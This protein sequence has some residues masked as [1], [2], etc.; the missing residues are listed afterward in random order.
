MPPPPPLA[1]RQAL[2]SSRALVGLPLCAPR[3]LAHLSGGGAGG[4]LWRGAV[5]QQRRGPG[6]G[7]GTGGRLPLRLQGAPQ[8]GPPQSQCVSRRFPFVPTPP[9]LFPPSPFLCAP[10]PQTADL[11]YRPLTGFADNSGVQLGVASHDA[12]FRAEASACVFRGHWVSFA[13]RS[14]ERRPWRLASSCTW[15]PHLP[16]VHA[17]GGAPSG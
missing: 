9:S 17:C 6:G 12:I 15:K 5:K 16:E 11:M 2:R 8:A 4:P 10:T 3:I 14:S 1:E 7:A 13:C